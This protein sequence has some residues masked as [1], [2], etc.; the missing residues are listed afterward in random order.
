MTETNNTGTMFY[1][2]N[3]YTKVQNK[4]NLRSEPL[5]STKKE[6]HRCNSTPV[7]SIVI[8]REH[9]ISLKK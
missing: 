5:E 9:N 8:Y 1:L 3:R 6:Y 2:E 4:I 7:T